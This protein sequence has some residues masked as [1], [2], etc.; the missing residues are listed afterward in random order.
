MHKMVPNGQISSNVPHVEGFLTTVGAQCGAKWC[1]RCCQ[2]IKNRHMCCILKAF[3]PQLVQRV[4]QNG[5][6]DAAKGQKSSHELQIEALFAT[7][8]AEGGGK[9]VHKMVP[10]GQK[11]SHVL[12]FEGFVI[13][14]CA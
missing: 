4:G 10:N 1:T 6:Q 8:G 11:S 14:V 5:A 2:M 3:R 9:L 7:I 12:H 13:T